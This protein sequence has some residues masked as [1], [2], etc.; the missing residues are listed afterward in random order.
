MLGNINAALN[1]TFQGVQSG[2]GY[3][4]GLLARDCEVLITETQDNLTELPRYR[5]LWKPDFDSYHSEVENDEIDVLNEI[6][7]SRMRL[8]ESVSGRGSKQIFQSI[9]A[10]LDMERAPGLVCSNLVSREENRTQYNAMIATM[11]D[12]RHCIQGIPAKVIILDGTAEI[13][14]EYLLDEYDFR[15][16]CQ[17]KRPLNHLRIKIINLNTTRSKLDSSDD[18]VK[19]VGRTVRQYVDTHG[20]RKDPNWVLFTY[21][22]H[23]ERLKDMIGA[24]NS[25][26]F[27][28]IVGKNNFK[29]AKHIV[30]I[31][32]NRFPEWV[33]FRCLLDEYLRDIDKQ[34]KQGQYAPGNPTNPSGSKGDKDDE[35]RQLVDVNERWKPYSTRVAFPPET[36]IDLMKS[37]SEILDRF[38]KRHAEEL[39]DTMCRSLFAEIEQMIFRGIIRNADCAE[40]Y[41]YHLFIDIE[42]Y[43]GVFS[44]MLDRYV[45]LGAKIEV[46]PTPPGAV[47]FDLMER[48]GA[49]GN[50]TQVQRLVKWHD[51]ELKVGDT[52]TD[53]DLHSASG[54]KSDSA[55]R[56]FKSTHRA[57]FAPMMSSENNSDGDGF[58]K[59]ANWYF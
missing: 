27:G 41:T 31:G 19:M 33:Y 1:G 40:D 9:H 25:D 53:A 59:V 49:H 45:P 55:W 57:W 10:I 46:L 56:K 3:T 47:L 8:E 36:P 51:C 14:P 48:S 5:F 26:Y 13:S 32:M 44:Q 16:D 23:R 22:D 24:P 20:I 42:K 15:D 50:E 17:T 37:Q 12:N 2:I 34:D 6:G 38:A 28:D 21:Q 29:E 54:S 35:L 43:P 4:L 39:Q 52:Y 7:R 18:Y 58:R 30:Q 11:T